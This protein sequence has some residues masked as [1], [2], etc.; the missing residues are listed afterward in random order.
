MLDNPA[1]ANPVLLSDID[2]FD[3]AIN[4]LKGSIIIET[5]KIKDSYILRSPKNRSLLYDELRSIVKASEMEPE[6]VAHCK[7][8]AEQEHASEKLLG[9]CG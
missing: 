7:D 2:K 8:L 3:N 6:Q 9:K 4:T 5:D 1:I